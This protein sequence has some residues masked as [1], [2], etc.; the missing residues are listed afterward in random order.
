M[1]YSRILIKPVVTEKS[2][3]VKDEHN[4]VVFAVAEGANKIQIK[5]AVQE[6]FKVDVQSV[7]IV[8]RRPTAK[9]RFG[10]R[11]GKLRGYKKAYITLA[12]GEKIDYF[13]GV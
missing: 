9:R 4:Q 6:A 5:K 7:N 11:M 1:D 12:P 8:R 10:R 13:E 2:T 3:V